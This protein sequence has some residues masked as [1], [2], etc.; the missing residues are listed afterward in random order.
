MIR[1]FIIVCALCICASC[2]KKPSIGKVHGTVMLNG[3]P[4]PD[5]SIRFIPIDGMTGTSGATIKNGSYEAN[6]VPVNKMRVE[7]NGFDMNVTEKKAAAKLKRQHDE[8]SIGTNSDYDLPLELIPEKY[9]SKS[10]LTLDV[11]EGDNPKDF[12]LSSK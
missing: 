2:S 8:N 9:N 1:L 5:G 12:N 4:L 11:Q 7:I 3:R 6:K 10:E